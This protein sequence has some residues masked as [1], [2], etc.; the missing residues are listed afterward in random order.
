M[1]NDA[2]ISQI[3]CWYRD[4]GQYISEAFTNRYNQRLIL[5]HEASTYFGDSA[6]TIIVENLSLRKRIKNIFSLESVNT[7]L[8]RDLARSGVLPFQIGFILDNGLFPLFGGY[9]PLAFLIFVALLLYFF[10]QS[11]KKGSG[12]FFSMNILY[13]FFAFASLSMS[14]GYIL[15]IFKNR[16]SFSA[17]QE[18]VSATLDYFIRLQSMEWVAMNIFMII[19]ATL[20]LFF[21]VFSEKMHGS[22]R[23]SSILRAAI[24]LIL[25]LSFITLYLL[26]TPFFNAQSPDYIVKAGYLHMANVGF[27]VIYVLGSAIVFYISTCESLDKII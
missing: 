23:K 27:G 6:E 14:D 21:R 2:I 18:N 25:I 4:V 7:I 8:R 26:Y 19:T 22:S 16:S 12:L 9:F 10:H 11:I 13:V 1:F 5:A 24:M 20:T 17:E 3:G 15:A